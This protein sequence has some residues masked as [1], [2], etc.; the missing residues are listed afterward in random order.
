M[1]RRSCRL[2]IQLLDEPVL[3]GAEEL[4]QRLDAAEY[5][6]PLVG[7]AHV[8]ALGEL[9]YQVTGAL[10]VG[11][12]TYGL[13]GGGEG[14]VLDERHAARVVDERIAG[15]ACGGLVGLAEAPVNDDEAPA[16][17][18]GVLALE[19]LYGDMSVDDV[20]VVALDT[21]LA[22]QKVGSAVLI[23][24]GIV[25]ALVLLHHG[26]VLQE[27]TFEGG[28]TVLV[29]GGGVLTAPQ[30]PQVVDGKL[31]QLGLAVGRAGGTYEGVDLVEQGTALV[32][33]VVEVHLLEGAVGIHGHRGV[34]EQVAVVHEVHAA[35]VEQQADVALQLLTGGEGVG[36]AFYDLALLDTE[37]VGVGGVDGGEM[38][39]AHTVVLATDGAYALRVVD[40]VEQQAVVHLVL[41]VAAYDV[42][43]ELELQHAHR[44]VHLGDEAACLVTAGD[45]LLEL[46]AKLLTGVVLID[47]HGKD[48]QMQ[49]V[50]AIAV[51]EHRE[52]AIAHAQTQH[53]GHA[54]TVAGSGT[55]PQH[56]VVA[57]LHVEVGMLAQGVHHEV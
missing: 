55:Y 45:I 36:D 14:L 13:F 25:A 39:L 38:A 30:V 50:D 44:L 47:L 4:T 53:V 52:V 18:H 22:E 9:L 24:Q 7:V 56:V 32:E 21:E 40:L 17:F 43:L 49:E 33:P 34:E 3:I 11:T 54:G 37:P 2:L 19:R 46:G 23:A 12:A 31:M 8:D 20:A 15:N 5:V 10:D 1:H 57:K 42:G 48:S 29:E 16:G 27:V 41:G 26:L 35:I 51:L 28:H 6:A